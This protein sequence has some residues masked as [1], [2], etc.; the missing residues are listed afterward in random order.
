[1]RIQ[2]SERT[3]RETGGLTSEEALISASDKCK[4][5]ELQ[6]LNWFNWLWKQ[7]N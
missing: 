7:Y 6:I 5:T 4:N 3:E 1:M 2:Q